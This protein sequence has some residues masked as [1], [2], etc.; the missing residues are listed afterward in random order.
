MFCNIIVL[1]GGGVEDTTFEANAKDSKKIR[2][3]G[4]SFREQILSRPKTGMVEANAKDHGSNFSK[5]WSVNFPLYLRAKV[6]KILH[7]VKFL[8]IIRK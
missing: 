8:M 1:I 4:P 7:F 5:L 2:G 3:H 6:F